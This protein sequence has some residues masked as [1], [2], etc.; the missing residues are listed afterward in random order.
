MANGLGGP[1]V[2]V[3]QSSWYVMQLLGSSALRKAPASA[4]PQSCTA[5]KTA[6]SYQLSA[7]LHCF[8]HCSE[9]HQSIKFNCFEM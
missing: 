8:E 4:T 9:S 3:S 2:S 6:T 5:T 1:G 7:L